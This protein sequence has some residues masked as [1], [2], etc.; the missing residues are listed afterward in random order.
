MKLGVIADC[1]R[2][3]IR[4]AV[5]KAAKDG[6]DGVQL[7]ATQGEFSPE[8][9]TRPSKTT[10]KNCSRT[11]T[12]AYPRFAPTPADTASSARRTT[13]PESKKRNV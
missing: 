7:Y 11:T 10:T 3:P 9:L 2:L 1:Y 8:N 12:F 13:L 5:L 4:E 6:F